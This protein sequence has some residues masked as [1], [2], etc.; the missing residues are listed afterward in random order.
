MNNCPRCDAVYCWSYVLD[1]KRCVCCGLIAGFPN[2]L[3]DAYFEDDG[4]HWQKQF[5]FDTRKYRV[6][7]SINAAAT[8]IHNLATDVRTIIPKQL[9]PKCN[10]WDIEKLLILMG[11]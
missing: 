10:D 11:S 9:S 2:T 7:I 1:R 8:Q 4:V 5:E 6:S 3:N